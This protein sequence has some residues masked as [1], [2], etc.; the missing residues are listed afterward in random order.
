[1]VNMRIEDRVRSDYFE[2]MYDLMCQGRF[3]KGITYRQLFTFLHDT[4]FIYFVPYDENRAEDGIALRYRFCLFHNCED[5]EYCLDGPCSVLEMMVALAIR[6]EERIM[7]DPEKGDRTAQWFWN[8]INSLG[9]SSMTDYNF[10]EW[11]VNDVITRFLKREYDPDG[12][13][14]LFTIKRWNHDARDTEIWRQLLAYL[15]TL[16]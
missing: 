4:E 1:M 8:M 9:L 5:L 14:G 7:A 3:A 13:G 10:N 6:C 16:G 15:N 12:K 2:W 11:L